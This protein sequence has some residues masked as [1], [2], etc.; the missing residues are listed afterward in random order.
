MPTFDI[1][2]IINEMPTK[3]YIKRTI[4]VENPV[5]RRLVLKLAKRI[6]YRTRLCESQNWKCCWCGCVM[7][8]LR[9]R[10]NS[11]TTEHITPSSQEGTDDLNNL[12]AA[13]NKCNNKRGVLP[14]EDFILLL[15]EEEKETKKKRRKRKRK[16]STSKNVV[17]L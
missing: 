12:A 4:W 2:L 17:S 1:P 13:C 6:Y 15:E 16:K 3:A 9:N 10:K 5:M 8:E 11:A 7:T 14:I